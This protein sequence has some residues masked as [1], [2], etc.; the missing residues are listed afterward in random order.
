MWYP[1]VVRCGD[2][3]VSVIKLRCWLSNYPSPKLGGNLRLKKKSKLIWKL[4]GSYEDFKAMQNPAASTAKLPPSKAAFTT[5]HVQRAYRARFGHLP[6]ALQQDWEQQHWSTI[7]K[8]TH[9]QGPCS[10]V[11]PV[12]LGSWHYRCLPVAL[13]LRLTVL[14]RQIETGQWAHT[15]HC[16]DP[17][18]YIGS[19]NYIKT[20]GWATGHHLRD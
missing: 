12:N 9:K 5:L 1:H 6:N 4:Q 2:M 16:S 13:L 8:H 20:W 18:R 10:Q 19:M 3:A 15:K 11:Q 14:K 17:Q 7:G